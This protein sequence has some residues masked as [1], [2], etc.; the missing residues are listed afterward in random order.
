MDL[1]RPALTEWQRQNF[2]AAM[3]SAPTLL[4][5]MFWGFLL[6]L[7][8]AERVWLEELLIWPLD[9]GRGD[10]PDDYRGDGPPPDW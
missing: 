8:G 6:Q 1:N 3:H 5:V 10:V 4:E 7:P 2:E 9:E